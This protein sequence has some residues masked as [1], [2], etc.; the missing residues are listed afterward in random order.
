MRAQAQGTPDK[1]KRLK[2]WEREDVLDQMQA[3]LSAGEWRRRLNRNSVLGP[4]S[5]TELHEARTAEQAPA[6][7]VDYLKSPCIPARRL[8]RL[9][10]SSSTASKP[11]FRMASQS[12]S[13]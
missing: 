11:P 6:E 8:S 7:L 4:G 3:R 12:A 9:I 13:G 2:R 1:L 10:C 5:A